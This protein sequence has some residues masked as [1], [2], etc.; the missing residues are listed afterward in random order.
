MEACNLTCIVAKTLSID[1]KY[2]L[3]MNTYSPPQSK[4]LLQTGLE[5]EL[6]GCCISWV[7]VMS[8]KDA[9]WA[10][11]PLVKWLSYSWRRH[12][13]QFPICQVFQPFSLVWRMQFSFQLAQW[14]QGE[15]NLLKAK[16]Y[17]LLAFKMLNQPES[18]HVCRK[19]HHLLYLRKFLCGSVPFLPDR[20]Y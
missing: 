1:C 10:F 15:D 17:V 12:Y 7:S 14:L 3:C 2:I 9:L 6:K 13:P 4:G 18:L 20:T 5:P 8:V 11:S 16:Y 19:M